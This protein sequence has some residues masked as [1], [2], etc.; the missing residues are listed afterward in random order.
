MKKCAALLF[1]LC[2]FGFSFAAR[3]QKTTMYK[4]G[5]VYASDE[6]ADVKCLESHT[7]FVLQH[8]ECRGIVAGKCKSDA[9][10]QEQNGGSKNYYCSKK[11]KK[12]EYQECTSTAKQTMFNA[13][14]VKKYSHMHSCVDNENGDGG[15]HCAVTCTW[16]M[17][18]EASG[19]DSDSVERI[20]LE[21]EVWKKPTQAMSLYQIK[22]LDKSHPQDDE[23]EA[24]QFKT[25]ELGEVKNCQYPYQGGGMPT[26]V[27]LPCNV[28]TGGSS[29]PD[30]TGKL[31][32]GK[33]PYFARSGA[34]DKYPCPE[35]RYIDSSESGYTLGCSSKASGGTFTGFPLRQSFFFATDYTK[36]YRSILR[37]NFETVAD[38]QQG[39]FS[40]GAY[41]EVRPLLG[42]PEFYHLGEP[43]ICGMYMDDRNAERRNFPAEETVHL[44]YIPAQQVVSA[45]LK[46]GNERAEV[47]DFRG[48]DRLAC[49]ATSMYKSELSGGRA[50][51]CIELDETNPDV[52]DMAD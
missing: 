39:L 38:T 47:W 14:C 21:M 23:F 6:D 10:C 46:R 48:R 13:P 16:D 28:L 41:A 26:P 2:V 35:G 32:L 45:R 49:C 4:L 40:S 30:S 33:M 44:I 31:T 9:E 50:M 7:G 24:P 37:S 3:A 36:A 5:Q 27:C 42:V 34:S 18:K 19:L 22:V 29:S 1:A 11:S 52:I 8:K 12:C 20:L 15:H 17:V 51:L 43:P 25:C